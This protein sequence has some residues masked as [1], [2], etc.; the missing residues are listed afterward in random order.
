MRWWT[1]NSDT[2]IGRVVSVDTS[3]VTVEL[4]PEL[5]ALARSTFEGPQE[6]GRINSYVVIPVGAR[7]LVAM[8]T[9]VLMTEESELTSDR[10]M[11]TLPSAR[12]LMRAT[13]IG[14]IEDGTFMQG[15][16]VFPVLH[17]PVHLVGQEDLS[18]IFDVQDA[19]GTVDPNNPGFIVGIGESLVF[20]GFSIN[21][22][23]DAMFGKHLA[24]LGSTGSGKSC[25]IAATL[26]AVLEL[27]GVSKT[28]VVIL[29]T[30]G[31][32]A[33]AFNQD[34]AEGEA[35]QS[36]HIPSSD[37]NAERLVI[38]YWFMNSDDFVRLFR[39]REGLQAPVLL[40]SLRLARAIGGQGPGADPLVVLDT[41]RIAVEKV[42][43]VA[44]NTA[45]NQQWAIKGNLIAV[46]DENLGF[47]AALPPVVQ[48]LDSKFGPAL[49]DSWE[50]GIQ[51]I[52]DLA[53][54][55]TQIGGT[56]QMQIR[57]AAN[58]LLSSL[59]SLIAE[60]GDE[61]EPVS[62]DQPSY[63][64]RTQLLEQYLDTAMREQADT[65]NPARVREACGPMFLRI[66]RFIE[67][68]RFR[69]LMTQFPDA[70]NV[71]AAFI[72]DIL[73][74]ESAA[75]TLADEDT[76]AAGLLPFYDRQRAGTTG[77]NIVII[78]LSLLASEVLEN[79]AALLGRLV[80]EFQQRVGECRPG[81]R[82]SLPV[83]MVLEEAQN[84]IPER[85]PA[86]ESIARAVFER[87]AREGR[88]YGLGLV[89]A[90]QRPSELSRTVL[91]QCSSFIV[92]RLQNP[93]DLRYFKE[94]V[95]GVYGALLDQLPSLAAR[96][97]LVF[98]EFVRA[99]ALVRIREAC[100]TPRSRD[101]KF[102]RSWVEGTSVDVED[103]CSAWENRPK[104]QSVAASGGDS[105]VQG[106]DTDG[107]SDDGSG[108]GFDASSTDIPV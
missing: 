68:R 84:Y 13:L 40:R 91:S 61:D 82:G 87:I 23:P 4:L 70:P 18:T 46:C 10:T 15:V 64:N 104:E 85:T 103:V 30:N 86:E 16:S 73:G 34:A 97:A 35:K 60:T 62:T 38:P 59:N 80:L 57:E 36:L 94:V 93:E 14:T 21:A 105:V 6:V 52:R 99:P 98:G 51:A 33:A 26:Q 100:P 12:R 90:S 101:P 77:S 49:F 78:D 3:Q 79:V 11:V 65:G 19:G 71:L 102:Y 24:V 27:P 48:Q 20:P 32:Y 66:R 107:G 28:T 47:R 75:A 42:L 89:V 25:T 45:A 55:A 81:A 53:D 44:E 5:K 92:H 83:V 72:R 31:E 29:D 74:M 1:L 8:V 37:E 50:A 63:F 2:E 54:A 106:A 96:C 58:P 17:S 7:R 22:D 41:L 108:S 76:V 56:T 67:D 43:A 95:P 69:F 88:K 9:R 39:A